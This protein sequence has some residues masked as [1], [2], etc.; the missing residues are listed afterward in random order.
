[1]RMSAGVSPLSDIHER[2]VNGEQQAPAYR[3]AGLFLANC[4]PVRS[5][6]PGPKGP[7]GIPGSGPTFEAM[8]DDSMPSGRSR[9]RLDAPLFS[10]TKERP[11]IGLGFHST[12]CSLV[13]LSVSSIGSSFPQLR[14]STMLFIE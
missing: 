12:G 8:S 10:W 14:R 5:A 13:L 6:E 4:C 7:F 11:I 1:M 9:R 2:P 3:R